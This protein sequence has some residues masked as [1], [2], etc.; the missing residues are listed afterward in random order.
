MNALQVMNP[1]GLAGMLAREAEHREL[2]GGVL[3]LGAAEGV[4][5]LSRYLSR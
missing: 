3:G 2:A 5:I 4:A 1:T